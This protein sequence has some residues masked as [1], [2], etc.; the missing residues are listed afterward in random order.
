MLAL[1]L[2]QLEQLYRHEL[3]IGA[4]SPFK[5]T[6]PRPTERWPSGLDEG[7]VQHIRAKNKERILH[8]LVQKIEPQEP[9]FPLPFRR[10]TQLRGE[11]Q[12]RQRMVE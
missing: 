9:G 6:M 5:A 10:G 12:P 11:V 2:S 1:T 7:H 8:A 4:A 3:P